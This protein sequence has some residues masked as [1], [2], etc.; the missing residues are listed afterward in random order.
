MFKDIE[1]VSKIFTK[2]AESSNN[3]NNS[4]DEVN[5]VMVEQVEDIIGAK[6]SLNDIESNVREIEK[7]LNE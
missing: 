3:I 4:A 7:V 6:N 5:K 2:I 1:Y